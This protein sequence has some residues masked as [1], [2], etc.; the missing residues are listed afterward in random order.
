MKI[1][2]FH[3]FS[4]PIPQR[5]TNETLRRQA[6]IRYALPVNQTHTN[7]V[8]QASVQPHNSNQSNWTANSQSRLINPAQI[9]NPAAPQYASNQ[10]RLPGSQVAPGN[11]RRT[12]KVNR[13]PNPAVSQVVSQTITPQN[14]N[15]SPQQQHASSSVQAITVCHKKSLP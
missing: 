4:A 11:R 6:E 12:N 9:S 15:S 10:V 2:L 5:P 3:C 14:I 7:S 1:N 13:P 8:S